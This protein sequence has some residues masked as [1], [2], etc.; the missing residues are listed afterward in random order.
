MSEIERLS[1]VQIRVLDVLKLHP[2]EVMLPQFIALMARCSPRAVKVHLHYIRC[3]LPR[4]EKIICA[5]FNKGYRY[6]GRAA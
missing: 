1:P 2:G 5:G 3:A 4:G 6:E